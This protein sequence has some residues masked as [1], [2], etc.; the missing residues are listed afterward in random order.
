VPHKNVF[1]RFSVIQQIGIL[2]I[3]KFSADSAEKIFSADF[4]LNFS[5]FP[6]FC[7]MALT[8]LYNSF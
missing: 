5:R 1:S 8:D 6:G 2:G 4:L 3:R 7:R